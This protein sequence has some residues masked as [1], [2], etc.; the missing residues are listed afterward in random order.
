M[1]RQLISQHH[2]SGQ[3]DDEP[4]FYEGCAPSHKSNSQY[5]TR[6]QEV[7][8]V[9]YE[10][11]APYNPCHKYHTS[12][13]SGYHRSYFNE[14]SAPSYSSYGNYNVYGQGVEPVFRE[15]TATN[16]TPYFH[17][18]GVGLGIMYPEYSEYSDTTPYADT[19]QSEVLPPPLSLAK[20]DSTSAVKPIWYGKY[21]YHGNCPVFEYSTVLEENEVAETIYWTP[22][23]ASFSSFSPTPA[24]PEDPRYLDEEDSISSLFQVDEDWE[25]QLIDSYA[26][27]EAE[28]VVKEEE[29]IFEPQA[30]FF[31][32]VA[33][34]ALEFL[35]P[36]PEP[37]YNELE[38]QNIDSTPRVNSKPKAY[39][40][41]SFTE[42]YLSR[43]CY[44]GL[45]KSVTSGTVTYVNAAEVGQVAEIA[46][47]DDELTPRDSGGS[48]TR[49]CLEKVISPKTYCQLFKRSGQSWKS[50]SKQRF[51]SR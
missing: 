33:D 14:D 23:N 10:D 34:S 30:S 15:A 1:S 2:V 40:A 38:Y 50:R 25:V 37:T 48:F 28:E 4:Y 51:E 13:G 3:E 27:D 5:Y 22:E 12:T 8:P 45:R 47:I 43:Y 19:Y 35:P 32:N 6:G 41:S 16:M 39:S 20:S 49:K 9:F 42:E 44:G 18:D 26:T 7:E 24:Y 31:C 36:T 17:D 21:S 29:C 11:T 46:H